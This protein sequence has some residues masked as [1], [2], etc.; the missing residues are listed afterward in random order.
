M[1]LFDW[2]K[3]ETPDHTD[4]SELLASVGSFDM[5]L[6]PSTLQLDNCPNASPVWQ[7]ST[8]P[9][10]FSTQDCSFPIDQP[11]ENTYE[12]VRLAKTSYNGLY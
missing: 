11:H 9:N 2:E 1:D 8:G 5:S 6:S 10:E 3:F 7:H 12:E 4:I